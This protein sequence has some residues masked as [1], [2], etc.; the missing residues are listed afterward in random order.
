[1][2]GR[3]RIFELPLRFVELRQPGVSVL[4]QIGEALVLTRAAW[5]GHEK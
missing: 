3:G 2:G 4:P 1:M 5:S